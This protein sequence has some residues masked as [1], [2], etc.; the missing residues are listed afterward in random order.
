VVHVLFVICIYL[1]KMVSN[2]IYI[3]HDV[4]VV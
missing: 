4:H 2:M 3:A 1:R